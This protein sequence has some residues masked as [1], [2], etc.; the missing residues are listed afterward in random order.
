MKSTNPLYPFTYRGVRLT[1]KNGQISAA[2][3]YLMSDELRQIIHTHRAALIAELQRMDNTYRILY[4]STSLDSWEADDPRYGYEV[5]LCGTIYRQL[6]PPYY[7][8]LRQR[9]DNARS[10][11]RNGK[12]N[13]AVYRQLT[14]AFNPIHEWAVGHYGQDALQEA[15]KDASADFASYEKPSA[16]TY[17]SYRAM[18]AAFEA[19]PVVVACEESKQVALA[20]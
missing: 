6:D 17:A 7:A 3:T 5:E 16:E 13:D 8:W 18:W 10:G 2:P 15:V 1:L 19:K 9:M 14:A 11:N 4:V 20:I 12:L